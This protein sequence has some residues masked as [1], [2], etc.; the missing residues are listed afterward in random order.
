[1]KLEYL[2]GIELGKEVNS[3]NL[4]PTELVDYFEKRIQEA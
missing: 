1:M 3:G 4:T 2:S